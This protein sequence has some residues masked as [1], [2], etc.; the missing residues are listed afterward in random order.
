MVKLGYTAIAHRT[1]LGS[2]RSLDNTCVAEVAKVQDL[3]LGQI[4]YRL[5]N[6][7]VHFIKLSPDIICIQVSIVLTET[8]PSELPHS[9]VK[10]VEIKIMMM[11][12]IRRVSVQAYNYVALKVPVKQSTMVNNIISS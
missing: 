3:A 6:G 2:H 9:K 7:I 11:I 8:I 1:M 4:K 5:K 10:C 12:K